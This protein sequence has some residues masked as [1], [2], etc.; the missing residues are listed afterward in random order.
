MDDS[1]RSVTPVSDGILVEF[2]DGAG[3]KVCCFPTSFL[4]QHLDNGHNQIFLDYDPSQERLATG[5][6]A[7]QNSPVCRAAA[8]HPMGAQGTTSLSVFGLGV[9]WCILF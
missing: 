7:S 9:R 3:G 4:L 2:S 1:I 5:R 8:H 6:N